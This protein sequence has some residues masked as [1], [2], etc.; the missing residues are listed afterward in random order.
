MRIL[1]IAF[2][3]MLCPSSMKEKGKSYIGHIQYCSGTFVVD[4]SWNLELEERGT[5]HFKIK[6]TDTKSFIDAR[7]RPEYSG[8]WT[9]KNDTLFLHNERLNKGSLDSVFLYRMKDS[10]LISLGNY[11]DSSWGFNYKNKVIMKLL[12]VQS[13]RN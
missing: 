4:R 1:I 2:V 11:V 5:Y 3:G 8:S 13:K 10:L 12:K 7:I 9:T 6:N